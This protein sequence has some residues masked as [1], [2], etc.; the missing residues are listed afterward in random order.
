VALVGGTAWLTASRRSWRIASSSTAS[1]R[2]SEPQDDRL[3]VIARS[4]EVAG[5]ESLNADTERI[6][7]RGGGECGGGDPD[8]SGEGEVVAER[9]GEPQA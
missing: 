4:I 1:R 6:E 5:D 8:A 2:R 7:E 9:A 3:G